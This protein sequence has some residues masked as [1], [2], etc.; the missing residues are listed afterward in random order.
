MMLYHEVFFF[1]CHVRYHEI[2]RVVVSPSVCGRCTHGVSAL[3]TFHYL[4]SPHWKRVSWLQICQG[5][6][7]KTPRDMRH[8]PNCTGVIEDE[9]HA[10]FDCPVYAD[11]REKFRDLFQEDCRTLVQLFSFDQDYT[12]LVK[13]LT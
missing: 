10:L 5:R 7:S 2:A 1:M 11:L 6:Y 13:F 3:E 4:T 9:Q 12:K 8:C